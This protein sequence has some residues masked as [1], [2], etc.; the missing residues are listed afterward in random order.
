MIDLGENIA[1]FLKKLSSYNH[2]CSSCCYE[3]SWAFNTFYHKQLEAVEELKQDAFDGSEIFTPCP[4]M[5]GVYFLLSL[6]CIRSGILIEVIRSKH[7]HWALEQ[8]K[9]SWHELFLCHLLDKLL[10]RVSC[11]TGSIPVPGDDLSTLFVRELCCHLAWIVGEDCR[12]RTNCSLP[13]ASLCRW[14]PRCFI[15]RLTRL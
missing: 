9:S 6:M 7:P 14:V 13:E 8:L 15:C 1:R 4:V 11:S 10:P 2:R 5:Y 3:L 12:L